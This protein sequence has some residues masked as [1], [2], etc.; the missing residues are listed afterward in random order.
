M[1][2]GVFDLN[3]EPVF[4]ALSYIWGDS[5]TIDEEEGSEI[6]IDHVMREMEPTTPEAG[7]SPYIEADTADAKPGVRI[8]FDTDS[9][10]FYLRPKA[11]PVETIATTAEKFT[12]WSSTGE[13]WSR[14]IAPAVLKI[15]RQTAPDSVTGYAKSL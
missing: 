1:P 14:T 9:L 10:S 12:V 15:R 5:V 2:H 4:N 3:D 8:T 13:L 11:V 6:N 7:D